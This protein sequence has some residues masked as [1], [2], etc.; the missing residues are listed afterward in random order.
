MFV[1]ILLFQHH[2]CQICY[3]LFFKLFQHNR[4]RPSSVS[5]STCKFDGPNDDNTA[6]LN[7]ICSCHQLSSGKTSKRCSTRTNLLP[8]NVWNGHARPSNLR[9]GCPS[10]WMCL[11]NLC[12]YP[13][14][15]QVGCEPPCNS[16]VCHWFMFPYPGEKQRCLMYL[17]RQLGFEIEIAVSSAYIS[18]LWLMGTHLCP[19]GIWGK[20]SLSLT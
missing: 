1:N 9:T 17:Y 2:S 8:A 10:N 4:L 12:I 14:F 13:S 19:L 20:G 6:F 5:I 7:K 3:L 11:E 16:T 18:E 15:L